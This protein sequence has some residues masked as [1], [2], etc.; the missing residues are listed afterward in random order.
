MNSSP[1]VL[2]RLFG[3]FSISVTLRFVRLAL[4]VLIIGMLGR[5]LGEHE[6]GQLLTAQAAIAVLLCF[7]ELGFARITVRELVRDPEDEART[8]GATF[9]TRLMAGTVMLAG[10]GLA[11]LGM[12]QTERLLLLAYGLLLP[13]HGFAELGSWI[14]GRG[15]LARGA[16][17]Q[18]WA[19][20]AGASMTIL[21]IA[22]KAPII[23]FPMAYVFE[24]WITS[25]FLMGVFH[26]LGGHMSDWR[27]TSR[28]AL[29]LLR[30]SWPEMT[31]QLA[32]VLLYRIDTIMV[33][34]MNGAEAAGIYGAAV[35]VSEVLYFLPVALAGVALPQLVEL[36][37][38][39]RRQYEKRFADYFAVSLL[40]AIAGAGCLYFA[41]QP[42][43][44]ALWKGRFAGSASILTIHAWAFIPYCLGVARTQYLTAESK[45]WANLPS[46]L[47]AL[48]VN[49]V[50]NWLWIPRWSGEGAAWATLIAYTVAWVVTSFLLPSVRPVAMLKLRS[51]AQMPALMIEFAK[52]ALERLDSRRGKPQT[53]S[54]S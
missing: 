50:L 48:V 8:L 18:L 34:A 11:T 29:E 41:A 43:I 12:P 30:E 37:K 2:G 1:R 3:V 6:M 35:R 51:F 45:L 4:N 16:W 7:A 23:F 21:G 44:T 42:I 5:F 10:L 19:F 53:H 24:C 47:L 46:V 49:V 52:R 40:L 26:G 54:P 36:K 32:L 33:K 27:W 17:V 22:I 9:Y 25:F 14:E 20:I 39:D 15:Q 13:T 31:A 38:R 28:R